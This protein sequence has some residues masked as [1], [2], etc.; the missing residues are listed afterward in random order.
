M[1]DCAVDSDGVVSPQIW[2][3]P[4]VGWRGWEFCWN[5]AW[6]AQVAKGELGRKTER[7]QRAKSEE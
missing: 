1:P 5:C 4:L 7:E 6:P 3:Y 2:R